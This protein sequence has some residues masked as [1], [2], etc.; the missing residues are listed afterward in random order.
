MPK[1]RSLHCATQQSAYRCRKNALSEYAS[2]VPSVPIQSTVREIAA[3]RTNQIASLGERFRERSLDG[4]P[5]P[6]PSRTVSFMCAHSRE[7]LT[8]EER[9]KP[10]RLDFNSR[11]ST[12]TDQHGK[13]A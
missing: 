3:N 2:S 5:E 4:N 1:L 12:L 13:D 6:D 10:H 8:I 11:I 7:N 9:G